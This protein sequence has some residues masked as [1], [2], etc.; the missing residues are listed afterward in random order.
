MITPNRGTTARRP[1]RALLVAVPLLAG[2]LLLSG[3]HDPADPEAVA[4]AATANP[5]FD[6][7][8]A[9]IPNLELEAEFAQ[10]REGFD[11]EISMAFAPVGQT[12]DAS[13]GSS[14]G[15]NTSGARVLAF[16]D[17]I[18]DVAWSTM[19][20]PLAIAALRENG[21][22]VMDLVIPAITY[23]DN[24]A[25]WS[26]WTTLGEDMGTWVDKFD[27]VLREGGDGS[28]VFEEDRLHSG[29]PSYGESIWDDEDQ[30]RFAAGLPCLPDSGPVLE[31]MGQIDEEQRWGLGAIEG[32]RFKGGW[33]PGEGEFLTRQFGIIDTPGGQT[34]VSIVARPNSGSLED[35][36]EM[37]TKMAAWI[38]AHQDQLPAGTC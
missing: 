24:D 20:V 27:A 23:S 16:G 28:T 22:D 17:D 29:G 32:A 3:C 14:S 11:G 15:L 4:A 37:L 30:V 35:G 18:E 38:V 9:G 6:G 36:N 33:G 31:L 34:A 25:T 7:A 5:K 12:D 1:R 8:V 21:P 13:P 2:A 10:L 26:L 19:K